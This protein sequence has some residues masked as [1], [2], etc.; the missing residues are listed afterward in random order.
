MAK[1]IGF[2]GLGN[3]G[4]PMA[5]RLLDAGYQLTVHDVR[6]E[7]AEALAAKGASIAASPA[8]LASAVDTLLLSLPNPA[9]VR[10]VALGKEGVAAGSKI[11][12]VIDLSTTGARCAREIAAALAVKG[13]ALVDSPVSGGVAGAV[14]GTLAVMVSCPKKT[15]AELG[16]MLKH[17]GK[18]FFI[19]ERPGMGQTM[20][21]ANN[22]L[23]ATALAA[24]SEA[25][26]F[27][28]KAG[29]DPAVMIDVINAG[30]GRNSAS[31]DKFPKSILPRSFD[32]GFT[33]GLMYKDLKL[34]LEEAEAAG[35]P[36][37][38]AN[39]VRQL[40]QHAHQEIGDDK[41]F[42]TIVQVL[43]RWAGVEVKP[44]EDA[45]HP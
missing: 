32:F 45:S 38:V 37:W 16:P 29:L 14:K 36:M 34:C 33:T 4:K 39:A 1:H 40:W 9:I 15:F 30:S 11:K 5:S 27:G 41:D 20:K 19:G 3:M 44:G 31:Q 22:L 6:R 24:T 18:V 25:I 7:S 26:V 12:T 43:E 17:I 35:V 2:I 13:I 10:E 28:V 8:A 21:L 42:T 23:S